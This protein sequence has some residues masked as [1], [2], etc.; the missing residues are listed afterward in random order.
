VPNTKTKTGS[1]KKT[2]RPAGWGG[3]RANSGGRRKGAGRKL[4][5]R[6]LDGFASLPEPPVDSL[7]GIEWAYQHLLV[8]MRQIATDERITDVQRRQELRSTAKAMGALLPRVRLRQAERL[9]LGERE[10]EKA[11]VDPQMEPSPAKPRAKA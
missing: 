3:A 11:M 2:K 5:E 10:R 7:A 8:A 9:I 1:G 6:R 4:E